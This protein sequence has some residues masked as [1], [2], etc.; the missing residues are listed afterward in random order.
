[1]KYS[2]ALMKVY[3][4]HLKAL[5]TNFALAIGNDRDGVHDMRVAIKRLRAF[6]QLVESL[7]GDFVAKN[8]FKPFKRF[9]KNT[10]VL[11]DLHVQQELVGK[12]TDELELDLCPYESF[13]RQYERESYNSFLGFS[14]KDPLSHIKPVKKCI[15]AAL[16]TLSPV[17]AETKAIGCLY[18]MRN[19]L[20]LLCSGSE[21][22]DDGLHIIRKL[23]KSI[24]YT[25]DIVLTCFDNVDEGKEYRDTV[26]ST[27]KMLGNWHDYA[28][29]IGY[30]DEFIASRPDPSSLDTCIRLKKHLVSRQ[31]D[32]RAEAVSSLSRLTSE[33]SL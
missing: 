3:S 18:N 28:V 29:S 26:I 20:I 22:S 15:Q 27:H 24:H 1:M 31:A 8:N 5:R 4:R 6:L 32:L 9:A 16:G 33:M 10:G 7:N 12:Y 19:H 17:W 23:T 25:H 21:P 13:L 11:R 2:D 14:E 30:L